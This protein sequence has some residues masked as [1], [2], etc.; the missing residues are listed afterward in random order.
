MDSEVKK[1]RL[2]IELLMMMGETPNSSFPITFKSC[3][4]EKD[5]DSSLYPKAQQQNQNQNH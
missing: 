1:A 4:K 3:K 5:I 2:K